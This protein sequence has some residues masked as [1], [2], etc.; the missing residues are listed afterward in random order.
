MGEIEGIDNK[1]Y[2][3]YENSGLE[4][5]DMIISINEKTVTQIKK[6]NKLKK[7]RFLYSQFY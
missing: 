3:P 6:H 2:K 5:G 1:K 4:E 7:N